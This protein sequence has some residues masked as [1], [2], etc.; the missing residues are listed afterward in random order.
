MS[1]KAEF[2][3]RFK[4]EFDQLIARGVAP[5]LAAA[6]A[7]NT[8]EGYFKEN[9]NRIS[10]SSSSQ[11]GISQE[12]CST[13]G[14]AP[15]ENPE[16]DGAPAAVKLESSIDDD[17]MVVEPEPEELLTKNADEYSS[18]SYEAFVEYLEGCVEFLAS[19]PGESTP[20][21]QEKQA[22]LIASITKVFSSPIQ[23]YNLCVYDEEDECKD[24]GNDVFGG[25]KDEHDALIMAIT[26]T[27]KPTSSSTHTADTVT[28]S[29]SDSTEPSSISMLSLLPSPTTI[30]INTQKVDTLLRLLECLAQVHADIGI[31]LS[32]ALTSVM[33]SVVSMGSSLWTICVC[34]VVLRYKQLYSDPACQS[35]LLQ[36]ILQIL[37]AASEEQLEKHLAPY[38]RGIGMRELGLQGN[39]PSTIEET[40]GFPTPTLLQLVE[41][42]QQ[43]I[44]IQLL[45]HQTLQVCV[46]MCMQ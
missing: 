6:Q 20:L 21:S 12:P 42:I 36:P 11:T 32:S 28:R 43:S 41:C 25:V 29:S 26:D 2:Q 35:S 15:K 14:L 24:E 10:S 45:E 19:V 23:L 16:I 30:N 46:V 7:I 38:W 8:T 40:A 3:S 9:P 5:Q 44:T 33:S 34:L 39:K 37:D 22:S 13:V 27:P 17:L 4:I 1:S 31:T 18:Q